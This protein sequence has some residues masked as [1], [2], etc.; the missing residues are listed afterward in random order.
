MAL[1][2]SVSVEATPNAQDLLVFS[3]SA[4]QDAAAN[5]STV[6]WMMQLVASTAGAINGVP[7]ERDW[8]VTVDGQEFA[9]TA[10]VNISNNETKTLA[11]GEIVLEHAE[12]GTR[13]F[14]FAFSQA[15]YITWSGT[16][17]IG[18]VSGSGTGELDAIT[19]PEPEPEK[20]DIQGFMIGLAMALCGRPVQW[21]K[22]DPV[23]YLY[24]H[25]IKE[26][27]TPHYTI[28][29]IGY[30]GFV[31]PDINTAWTD[32]DTYKHASIYKQSGTNS[33]GEAVNIYWLILTSAELDTSE[34]MVSKFHA[35]LARYRYNPKIDNNWTLVE[36]LSEGYDTVVYTQIMW[37]TYDIYT[38]DTGVLF[39]AAI[40]PIPMYE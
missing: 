22:R 2:G 10:D 29:G 26:G 3:W 14:D 7:V 20:F 35:P 13:S 4:V 24:G 36:E 28:D 32:K 38:T 5:A 40:D 1:N 34:G 33:S 23:A 8:T 25:V 30:H 18:V 27:E 39:Q 21:P 17:E 16:T 31:L 6:S 15:L 11:A 12:D 19:E 37:A 9:G